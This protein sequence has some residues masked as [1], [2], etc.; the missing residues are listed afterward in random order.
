[1]NYLLEY[2]L[3][4]INLIAIYND[5]GYFTCQ[6]KDYPNDILESDNII[7]TFGKNFIEFFSFSQIIDNNDINNNKILNYL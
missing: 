1:M 7:V 5:Q 3:D 6:S 4:A 2:S